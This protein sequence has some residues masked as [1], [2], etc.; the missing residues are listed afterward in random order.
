MTD[1]WEVV[2]T[3]SFIPRLMHVCMAS[4]TVGAA[5]MLSVSSWYLLKK[6]HLEL[7]K[8]NLRVA[9]PVFILFASVNVV[10]LRG[11]PWR[12]R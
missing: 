8:S 10:D 11:Q 7:A 4:W 1:F 12:S 3:K 6:R 5:L 9:L 2:F